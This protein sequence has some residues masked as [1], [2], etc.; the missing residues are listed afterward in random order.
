MA[1]AMW[2]GAIQFGL[3]T[4]P[5][6]LY[7]ATES[8][9]GI[10]FNMLHKTDLT[11]IQ[12]KTWCPT[13]DKAIS[14]TRHRARLRMGARP[15]RRD[16]GRG[17]R[18]RAAQDG[19][20]DRDRAV[21]AEGRRRPATR[22]SSRRPTTSSRIAIGRKAFSLLK[23]ILTEKGLTA[24]CKVV[25]KDREALAALDPFGPT[26]L[27]TTLA[28]P[29]EIR[30]VKDL[31]LP[32]ETQTFK[33][34]ERA[35]AEQLIAAMTGA[36]NPAE[37]HDEYREALMKVIES[38]VEGKQVFTP[39]VA[40]QGSNL[41]DL[42]AALEASVEAARQSRDGAGAGKPVSVKEARARPGR[43]TQTLR[44]PRRRRHPQDEHRQGVRSDCRPRRPTSPKRSD[45]P[46]AARAPDRLGRP[47]R[48]RSSDTA[49]SAISARR[50]S[51]PAGN[52]RR[53]PRI[54]AGSSSSATAPRGCTTTSGSRSAAFSSAGPCRRARASIRR[55]AG[56]PSTSRITRSSTSTSKA[57][58]RRGQYGAGDV[59]VWDWGTW[60]AEAPTLDAAKAVRDGELKFRIFGEKLKGR[61]TIVRTG[62]GERRAHRRQ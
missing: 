12:M 41:V 54:A 47:D 36:F 14:R 2:K 33:P 13:E 34:A 59:I 23:E 60:E 42:M 40:E 11:R 24:I 50:R 51:P 37:Y 1:R 10:S 4:I 39:Q 43:R 56:W 15:V 46:V 28:W 21:R 16:H 35:M 31:D 45:R 27:L 22:A 9:R 29:D 32:A 53:S 8:S 17:P 18:S 57:S 55:S 5:V 62:R 49:T 61:F 7:L 58:S 44:L 48:C 19:P 30:D 52:S 38:K 3:V 6:K 26:M 20:I 25:I